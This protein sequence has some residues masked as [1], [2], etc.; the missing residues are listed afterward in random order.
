MANHQGSGRGW[1]IAGMALSI[2][3]SALMPS[4]DRLLSWNLLPQLQSA[5]SP[6]EVH[7]PSSY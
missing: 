7:G 2:A 5:E 3:F 1:L 6:T 4:C